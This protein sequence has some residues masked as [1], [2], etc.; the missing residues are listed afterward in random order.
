[1]SW[2]RRRRHFFSQW[3]IFIFHRR[4]QLA[5]SLLNNTP[6]RSTAAHSHTSQLSK[7]Q[8]LYTEHLNY[9]SWVSSALL[10]GTLT[11][12][13]FNCVLASL[14]LQ[15]VYLPET[16]TFQIYLHV[17]AQLL[18][19]LFNYLLQCYDVIISIIGF[20]TQLAELQ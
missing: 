5:H 17:F 6:D 19:N 14:P 18:K 10:K 15:R 13:A 9:S 4:V 8:L 1:M 11:R 20:E 3:E 16:L 12:T 7:C 2:R